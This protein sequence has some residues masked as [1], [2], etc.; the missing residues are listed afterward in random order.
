MKKTDLDSYY[1]LLI[2]KYCEYF[3]LPSEDVRGKIRKKEYVMARY[4][5]MRFLKETTD[6]SLSKIGSF[7]DGR[8]HSSV[9]HAIN[10][11]KDLSGHLKLERGKVL[12]VDEVD[13]YEEWDGFLN[14]ANFLEDDI[15]V[16]DS[17]H[18]IKNGGKIS[19]DMH[20]KA[21]SEVREKMIFYF[22]SKLRDLKGKTINESL[23]E[24]I[25]LRD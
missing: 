22:K 5:I 9:I 11:H 2:D 23:I 1:E 14:Y 16:L 13:F 18:L 7:F 25:D 6:M 17:I 4:H 8:D 19:I 24:K 15:S 12:T 20:R 3:K 21:L 10:T